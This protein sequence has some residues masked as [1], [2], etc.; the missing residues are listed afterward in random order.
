MLKTRSLAED[1]TPS[2]EWEARQA[3]AERLTIKARDLASSWGVQ[4]TNRVKNHGQ[5]LSTV[6]WK[7]RQWATTYG[8]ECRDGRYVIERSR[9]WANDEKY[10]WVRHMATKVWVDLEDF[11]EAL[12]AARIFERYR[13]GRPR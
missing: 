10:S 12:R 13:T 9:L 2:A 6:I 4:G 8:V 7:G 3:L 5:R 11:A 1:W